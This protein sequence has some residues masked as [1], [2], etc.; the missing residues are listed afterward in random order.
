MTTQDERMRLVLLAGLARG[1][2]A[3][4]DTG[5]SS[6]ILRVC[7]FCDRLVAM[8]AGTAACKADYRSAQYDI[9]RHADEELID[10]ILGHVLTADSE[11]RL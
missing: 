8:V 4:Y 11:L 3:L 1:L 10:I 5:D 6:Q 9:M 2:Q 7:A